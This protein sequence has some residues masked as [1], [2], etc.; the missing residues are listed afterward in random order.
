M[1]LGLFI[2]FFM[3]HRRLWIKVVE[4]KNTSRVIIGATANKNR[5]AFE[6]KIDKMT[7]VLSKKQEGEK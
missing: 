2:A 5:A 4:E 7:S 1:S 6:R 3:S